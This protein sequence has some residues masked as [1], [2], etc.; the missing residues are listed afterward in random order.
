M[1]HLFKA[2]LKIGTKVIIIWQSVF[3]WY[4]G[5]SAEWEFKKAYF[6]SLM[7]L[8]GSVLSSVPFLLVMD[9]FSLNFNSLESASLLTTSLLVA[10]YTYVSHGWHPNSFACLEASVSAVP[11]IVDSNLNIGK[12]EIIPISHNSC[13]PS[14]T[15]GV[16]SQVSWLLVELGSFC[17]WWE[18]QEGQRDFLLL[19][20]YIEAF[21]GDL[22]SLPSKT[23]IDTCNA[24]TSL[25]VRTGFVQFAWYKLERSLEELS[26]KH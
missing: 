17:N 8:K 7:W 15:C 2:I 24:N 26:K 6:H 23:T 16:Y 1:V 25:A 11:Y 20:Q 3:M 21:L 10:L 18:H 12:C 4:M 13:L 14:S 22:S 9:H 19:W 5:P